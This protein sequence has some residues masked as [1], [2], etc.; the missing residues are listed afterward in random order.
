MVPVGLPIAAVYLHAADWATMP[1]LRRHALRAQPGASGFR[2]GV[3]ISSGILPHRHT[4]CTL[5]GLLGGLLA[6]ARYAS[7]AGLRRAGL[8]RPA[9]RHLRGLT[10]RPLDLAVLFPDALI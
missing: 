10:P 4:G 5:D 8:F 1:R 7:P 6:S 3:S 9:S 2:A